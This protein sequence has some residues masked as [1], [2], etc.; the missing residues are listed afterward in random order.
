MNN[1]KLTC[2]DFLKELNTVCHFMSRERTGKATNS[3]LK[4]WLQNKAVVINNHKVAFDDLVPFP[5]TQMCLFPK[6]KRIT[7]I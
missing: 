5:V 6:S 4:R 3:E 2:W 1:S 7:L